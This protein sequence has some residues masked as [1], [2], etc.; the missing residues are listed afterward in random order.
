MMDSSSVGNSIKL[1]LTS[2]TD[3]HSFSCMRVH[4]FHFCKY[5]KLMLPFFLAF[6]VV[7]LCSLKVLTEQ[8][9]CVISRNIFFVN[10][11]NKQYLVPVFS[12]T[13]S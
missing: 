3:T 1:K 11:K 7:G 8:K 12:E 6:E 4:L 2:L 13:I 9:L 10:G 5:G